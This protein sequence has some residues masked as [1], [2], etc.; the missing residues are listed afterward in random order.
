MPTEIKIF[1]LRIYKKYKI[2]TI[3]SFTLLSVGIL[4]FY[5]L[6]HAPFGP[7]LN[8]SIVVF[9]AIYPELG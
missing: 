6:T 1:I 8:E 9:I 7:S 5:Y 3:Q 4:F 2:P